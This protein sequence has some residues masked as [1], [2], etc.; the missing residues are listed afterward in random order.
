MKYLLIFFWLAPVCTLAQDGERF[1]KS[2][3][4]MMALNRTPSPSNQ[5][6]YGTTRERRQFDTL[7]ATTQNYRNRMNSY[8]WQEDYEQ[9]TIWMEK[10]AAAYPKEAG[11]VGE[12]Y[13]DLRDY[14]RALR[15][16]DAYDALTANFDDIVFN[17]PVS[18][19]RGLALCSM[20][21]HS[22]AIEQFTRTIS[23]LEIKH[24]AEWVNYRQ[25]V[26][27]A[28][29]YLI[30]GR[31]DKALA[32]LDNAAKNYVRSALVRF[33][34]GRALQQLGRLAEART[35]YLDASFFYKALRAER[36]MNYQ[37]DPY[38]PLYEP[39]IDAALEAIK[40]KP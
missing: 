15:H 25:Y 26:S 31:A 20:G 16:F 12:S 8:I 7:S 35:A 4:S 40:A 39:E 32:D 6:G 37:E 2:C 29:S 19:Y 9:A 14:A 27:R 10:T 28:V 18:Y 11:A 24:G 17:S 22:A 30:T 38:N 34:R 1:L 5:F 23:A 36:D 33:H 3:A 21:K 13:L